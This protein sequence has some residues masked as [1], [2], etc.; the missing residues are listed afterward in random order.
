M[1]FHPSLSDS[2]RQTVNAASFSNRAKCGEK[3][4]VIEQRAERSSGLSCVTD[5]PEMFVLLDLLDITPSTCVL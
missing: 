1:S 4:E 5:E 3:G 2:T